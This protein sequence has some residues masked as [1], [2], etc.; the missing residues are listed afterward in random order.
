M[1]LYFVLY[2]VNEKRN[3]AIDVENKHSNHTT[4][5]RQSQFKI[6]PGTKHFI[7]RFLKFSKSITMKYKIQV[8][9]I[10]NKFVF[11]TKV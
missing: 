9:L 10:Y 8:S 2:S 5:K 3:G 11:S 1:Y 4:R 6:T 7:F